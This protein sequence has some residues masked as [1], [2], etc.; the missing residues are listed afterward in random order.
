M[1]STP[2][3]FSLFAAIAVSGA[4]VSS[5]ASAEPSIGEPLGVSVALVVCSCER[6]YA[7]HGL[8]RREGDSSA[9]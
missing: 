1:R 6:L 2:A 8:A 5:P 4:V 3:I 9:L 7:A